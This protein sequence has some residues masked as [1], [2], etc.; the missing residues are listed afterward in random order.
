MPAQH[1]SREYEISAI[2]SDRDAR[3]GSDVVSGIR[4]EAYRLP[5]THRSAQN[6]MRLGREKRADMFSRSG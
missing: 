5:G 3:S 2:C 4:H 1:L 6:Q